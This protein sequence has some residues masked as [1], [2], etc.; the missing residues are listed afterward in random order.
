[1]EHDELNDRESDYSEQYSEATESK[2]DVSSKTKKKD[3]DTSQEWEDY[4]SESEV[5]KSGSYSAKRAL[6]DELQKKYAL[7]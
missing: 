3:A 4:N 5:S 7:K 2:D 6:W 1:V